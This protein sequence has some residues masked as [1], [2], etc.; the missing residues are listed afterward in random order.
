MPTTLDRADADKPK[1]GT[2]LIGND[3]ARYNTK[4]AAVS[5][6]QFAEKGELHER[7]IGYTF[8]LEFKR[9]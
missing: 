3:L 6:T 4:T 9:K 2:A 8:F 1:R 7:G 5:E